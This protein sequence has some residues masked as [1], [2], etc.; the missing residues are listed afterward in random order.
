M[1]HDNINRGGGALEVMVPVPECFEDSKQ[2]LIVGVIV[3]LRGSQ[4]PGVVCDRTNLSIGASDRQ[5]TSDSIVR[6]I[7]FHNDRGIWNEVSEYGH[8]GEG[9]LESVEGTSTVLGEVPRSIF[10]GEPGERDHNVQV[11]EYKPAVEVGK[12]QERLDVL[13]LLRFRP[14]RDG[15]DLVQRHS[16]TFWR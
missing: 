12:A 10:P 6:G 15:L 1:V 5:D 2:L 9:V 7:S 16:Q 3:Q 13:H 8:S 11:V 4:S 14:V